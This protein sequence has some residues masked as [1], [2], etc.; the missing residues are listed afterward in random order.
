MW[1]DL[2]A[3]LALL[4]II[5]GIVPFLNPEFMRRMVIGMLKINDQTLRFAGLSSMV[6][7]VLLLY[8]LRQ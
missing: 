2:L 8:L 3:A 4:L 6:A 5:E 7:G 1:Q